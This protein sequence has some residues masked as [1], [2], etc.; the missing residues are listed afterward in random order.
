VSALLLLA[1]LHGDVE[2]QIASLGRLIEASPENAR[3]R[4]RRGEL[5]RLHGETHAVEPEASTSFARAEEDFT[6]ALE[7]GLSEARLSRARVRLAAKRPAAAL[8]DVEAFLVAAPGHAR[9]RAYEARALAALGKGEAA[10][11]AYAKA[12][13]LDAAPPPDLYLE[14]AAAQEA[15]GRRDDA[16]RGLDEGAARLGPLP[17]LELRALEL[18]L[19][20][21]LNEA[22]LARAD[23][24]LERPGRKDAWRLR[25]AEILAKLGRAEEARAAAAQTLAEIDALPAGRRETADARE[26]RR[27]AS[28]LAK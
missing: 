17:A 9:A 15:L 3:H 5:W 19:A 6:K 13:R 28:E 4:L 12:L 11:E 2:E 27:R 18:E 25:R 20:G 1:A 10:V 22:A 16:I 8:E 24:G 14:R 7:L 23:R 21:G 26:L